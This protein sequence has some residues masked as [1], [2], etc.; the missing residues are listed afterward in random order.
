MIDDEQ[1]GWKV[2]RGKQRPP[3]DE[4]ANLCQIPMTLRARSSSHLKAQI[5]GRSA[6]ECSSHVQGCLL[7]STRRLLSG[8]SK[9]PS[10]M[11]TM[12]LGTATR[13]TFP[14]LPCYSVLHLAPPQIGVEEPTASRELAAFLSEMLLRPGTGRDNRSIIFKIM[15]PHAH[16]QSLPERSQ[17]SRGNICFGQDCLHAPLFL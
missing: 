14:A 12:A 11:T 5:H 4:Q 16:R 17:E 13:T 10:S 8:I 15:A 3:I 7:A 6:R 1:M 2:D 9:M